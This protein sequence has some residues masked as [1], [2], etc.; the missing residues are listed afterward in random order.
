MSLLQQDSSE[1]DD[2][3]RGEDLVKGTS[4]VVWAV[5]ISVALAAVAITIYVVTTRRPPDAAAEVLSVWVHPQHT[6]TSGFD[7][8][9]SRMPIES[10]DQVM[11]FTRVRLHNQSTR[12][13]FLTNA[14]TNVTLKDGIHSAYAAGKG[15]YDRIFIAYPG[16][17][18]PH[19]PPLATMDTTIEP[20][21]SVEGA[22][23]SVFRVTKQEWD[24]HTKLDY[25]F[26]FQYQPNLVVAPRI[27][28]T[29]Q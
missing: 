17:P 28:V 11:V 8:N 26:S 3:A 20:G 13:L 5:I 9:G 10:F 12:P 22:F 18:A 15:D 29:E 14:T 4:H 27:Q 1:L 7:A 2:A 19:D 24:A 23:V 21:Q 25:T 16:M 6:E